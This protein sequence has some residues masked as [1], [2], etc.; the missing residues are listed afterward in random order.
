L[1]SSLPAE[2]VGRLDPDEL[3]ST[4]EANRPELRAMLDDLERHEMAMA[5]ARRDHLPDITV[6]AGV[7]GVGERGDPA[8]IAA[9]PPDNGKNIFS[10]SVGFNI[11]IRRDRYDAAEREAG[12]QRVATLE[13]YRAAVDDMEYAIRD[14]VLRLETLERQMALYRD[15]LLPQTESALESAESAYETGLV[16]STELLESERVLLD[17]RITQ[18]R[19]TADY[20]KA[21]ARL[22]LALGTRFPDL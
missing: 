4:G 22:E 3:F 18:A 19:F 12:E 16:G 9:P 5:R 1:A 13:R 8:G 11:P 6:G 7:V 17:I 10:L 15:V 2:Q 14:E 20:L 21:L